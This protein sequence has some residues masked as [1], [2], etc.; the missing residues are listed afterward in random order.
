LNIKNGFL[1]LVR[2][3]RVASNVTQIQN[4]PPVAGE[5]FRGL[6]LEDIPGGCDPLRIRAILL[7]NPEELKRLRYSN[8]DLA[9]AVEDPDPN[10]VREVMMK[11]EL[12]L[13]TKR[14]QS[15]MAE[16]NLRQRL[17]NN[18]MD[19]EAQRELERIIQQRNIQQNMNIAMEH[20]PESFASVTMLYVDCKVNDVPVKAF[21]D[22]G[23]QMTIMSES[24]ARKC[25]IM[26][27]VDTR[28]AGTAVGVGSAKILGRV[29]MC[30]LKI[31]KCFF[32]CT[33]MYVCFSSLS[34][35]NILIH[36]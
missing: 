14:I 34:L 35:L 20:M 7:A 30:R 23:A 8:R 11:Q 17:M 9:N 12:E 10:K 22:S 32:P 19:I 29:H 31:G 4:G 6:K 28:Y 16:R 26:R 33:S 5:D 1:I 24:C 21:V 18:P 27:L 36:T 13:A 3:K 2:R 15:D 25:N